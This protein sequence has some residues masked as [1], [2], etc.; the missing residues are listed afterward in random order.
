MWGALAHGMY[1]WDAFD[2]EIMCLTCYY[3]YMYCI[4]IYTWW[5][6]YAPVRACDD[7]GY[8]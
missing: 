5:E 6:L 3:T 2:A 7:D 1:L 4:Y 8:F